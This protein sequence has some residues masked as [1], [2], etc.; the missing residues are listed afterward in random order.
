VTPGTSTSGTTSWPRSA[1][2]AAT[3]Y[4]EISEAIFELRGLGMSASLQR[5]PAKALTLLAAAEAELDRLGVEWRGVRFWKAL[6]DRWTE[7]ARA[8]LTAEDAEG[9]WAEGLG[10]GFDRL[11]REAL[12]RAGASD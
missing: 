11:S 12:D 4:G 7:N 10:R 5:R 9:A 3:D 1:L 8:A 2:R 6:V